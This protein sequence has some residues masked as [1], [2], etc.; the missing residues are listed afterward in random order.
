M[1]ITSFGMLLLCYWKESE[2]T[3][4]ASCPYRKIT[5]RFE[6]NV[7]RIVYIKRTQNATDKQPLNQIFSTSCNAYI[8]RCTLSSKQLGDQ[9]SHLDTTENPE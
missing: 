3:R 7:P 2:E 4:D 1:L 8:A 6:R 5:Q 9:K